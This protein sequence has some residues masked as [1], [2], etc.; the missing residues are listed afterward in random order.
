MVAWIPAVV[1]VASDHDSRELVTTVA[2]VLG[3]LAV[4]STVTV[5][6]VLGYRRAWG[7]LGWSILFGTAM[8]AIFMFGAFAGSQPAN[9]PDDP[10]LGIGAA[11]VTIALLP[12]LALFL[13]FGGAIGM[14]ACRLTKA[15]ST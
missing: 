5:G 2:V 3:G 12:A 10:G 9:T 6:G 7:Y 13:W 4:L 14:F 1:T 15:K 11:F 8:V